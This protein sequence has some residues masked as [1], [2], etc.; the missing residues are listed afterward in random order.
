MLISIISI[1]FDHSDDLVG[2]FGCIPERAVEEGNIGKNIGKGLRRIM[3]PKKT[4]EAMKRL[5][6]IKK[7]KKAKELAKLQKAQKIKNIGKLRKVAKV[8]GVAG[9]GVKLVAKG[10]GKVGGLAAKIFGKA[11]GVIS[12]A[13]KG[14]KPFL[15]KFFGKIPIVGPLVITI[16]SL[17]NFFAC[18]IATKNA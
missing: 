5:N 13:F 16:V 17:L 15:S 14:A 6:N 11:A 1:I 12:P 10:A 4:A 3:H 8:K 9:K 7:I 2:Y 18:L